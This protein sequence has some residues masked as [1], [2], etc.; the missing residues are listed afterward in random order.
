MSGDHFY[1]PAEDTIT[2]EQSMLLYVCAYVLVFPL[3]AGTADSGI[4]LHVES[5]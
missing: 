3:M 4:P 5:G 2:E 1:I